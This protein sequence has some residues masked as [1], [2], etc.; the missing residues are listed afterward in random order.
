MKFS[1]KEKYINNV[2]R[3]VGKKYKFRQTDY[4]NWKI[5]DGFYFC[6]KTLTPKKTE[7]F[8]KPL[9][10][11]DLYWKMVNPSGMKWS[12][13]DR[14]YGV[15]GYLIWEER[16]PKSLVAEFSPEQSERIWEDVYQKVE[17]EINS[18][19]RKYPHPDCFARYVAGLE[20]TSS[21]TEM[22]IKV[23]EGKTDEAYRIAKACIDRGEKGTRAWSMPGEQGYKHE[24]EF[25]LDYCLP[26]G[27]EAP[28]LP[29]PSLPE[30]TPSVQPL[31]VQE[32]GKGLKLTKA[33]LNK[34]VRPGLEKLGYVFLKDSITGA[35]GLFGKKLPN[36]LYLTLALTIH[37]FYD[38]AFTADFEL[39]KTA[40]VFGIPSVSRKRPGYLLT[41]E[42]L[43]ERN[44]T[45]PDIW[46]NGYDAESVASFVAL[47][48]KTEPRFLSQE[49]IVEKIEQSSA[50]EEYY[51]RSLLVR[52]WVA[53]GVP[54]MDFE[55]L[56]GKCIDNIPMEWFKAA[57]YVLLEREEYLS[58]N[59]WNVKNLAG[60]AYRQSV[61]DGLI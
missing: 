17:W 6:L 26:V 23:Y 8:V 34:A 59:A 24:Y 31:P 61:L 33:K 12:D 51:Q 37:R 55:C 44:E 16:L 41:K 35:Q 30:A 46:W 38:D 2:R 7:L 5:R 50:E 58:L 27:V 40:E 45:A 13:N 32:T 21:L 42:E 57:E 49:G 22:L 53:K 10:M 15:E 14:W 25:I 20:K 18:F 19:L 28:S 1:E 11:D 3:S 52:E 56:P 60:N 47:I 36:G 43:A 4:V 54:D 9:Y 39:S 48:Q 29:T